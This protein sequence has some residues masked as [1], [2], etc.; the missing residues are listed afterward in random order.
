MPKRLGLGHDLVMGREV[1]RHGGADAHHVA[2]R[3]IR[4]LA[5]HEISDRFRERR[6][7][8]VEIAAAIE[9]EAADMDMFDALREAD[10]VGH[11]HDDDLAFQHALGIGLVEPAH[12]MV[13]HQHARQFIRVQ[14]CLEV[15]EGPGV[16]RTVAHH[17]QAARGAR[18][19]RGKGDEI[20]LL[21]HERMPLVRTRLFA[22]S[23]Q[24]GARRV[25]GEKLWNN[26]SVSLLLPAGLTHNFF[27]INS[28]PSWMLSSLKMLV[29]SQAGVDRWFG[30]TG[31]EA[32][33]PNTKKSRH[34]LCSVLF[35]AAHSLRSHE[36]GNPASQSVCPRLRLPLSWER[37]MGLGRVILTKNYYLLQCIGV[38]LVQEGLDWLGCVRD[39]KRVQDEELLSSSA[40]C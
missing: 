9:V 11:R 35:L 15:D 12:E 10:R 29:P 14:P 6:V 1:A 13:E 25:L 34:Q 4:Q 3:G 31:G 40:C 2:F 7:V 37:G 39:L 18:A 30:L 33:T 28:D 20:G 8:P 23:R 5:L 38:L 17:A 16:G 36:S 27:G 21:G 19:C 22:G 26:R 32:T 24:G